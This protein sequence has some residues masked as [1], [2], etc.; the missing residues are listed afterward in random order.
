MR[1][2]LLNSNYDKVLQRL[3]LSNKVAELFSSIL[4]DVNISTHKTDYLQE[5]RFLLKQIDEHE[6]VLA[7]AR[8][9]FIADQLQFD[10]FKEL[11]KEHNTISGNQKKELDAIT[12][13]L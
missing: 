12:V 10:D 4:Q 7:K 1:A 3:K 9:L 5:R 2:D 8:K 13:K 11:K 6:S